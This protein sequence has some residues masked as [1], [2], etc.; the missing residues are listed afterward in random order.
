[1]KLI[2]DYKIGKTKIVIVNVNVGEMCLERRWPKDYFVSLLNSLLK[3]PDFSFIFIGTDEDYN[4]VQ[5]IIDLLDKKEK[6]V[7][8]AGK[9][10]LGQ[11]L[12]LFQAAD[13]FITSDSGPLHLAAL[14]KIKTIS[15][16]GPETPVLYGPKNPN[17]V[18][19]YKG[20][21]CSPCLNVY[22]VKTA[23]YGNKRCFEGN[24]KCMYSI[25]VEEVLEKAKELLG[26]NN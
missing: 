2:C 5:S 19:F 22:N 20:P 6:I 24:N 21:Y 25:T 14:T 4:Y 9:A 23:M 17:H 11:L 7:N 8:L 10:S 1:M 15:F 18:V 3:Y 16:F 12:T 13:L 26:M